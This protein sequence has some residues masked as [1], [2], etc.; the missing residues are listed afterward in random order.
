[1]K[2]VKYNIKAWKE[3]GWIKLKGT[4]DFGIDNESY[5]VK[6][7][8]KKDKSGNANFKPSIF[9][10]KTMRDHFGE[11]ARKTFRTIKKNKDKY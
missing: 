2:S 10:N 1:M 6:A 4:W 8:W 11:S 5:K 9:G 3:Y 7:V